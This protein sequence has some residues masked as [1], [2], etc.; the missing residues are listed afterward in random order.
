[1]TE[2]KSLR[3]FLEVALKAVAPAT[4]I[5]GNPQIGGDGKPVMEPVVDI[6]EI[7]KRLADR[8]MFKDIEKLIPSLKEERERKQIKNQAET[9]KTSPQSNLPGLGSPSGGG[10]Q[11][12]PIPPQGGQ[13]E[14][15]G[16]V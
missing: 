2:L 5:M 4:D 10:N 11:P 9:K 8:F 15:K 7:V 13:N 6:R 3:E 14:A 12:S 16:V 1:M